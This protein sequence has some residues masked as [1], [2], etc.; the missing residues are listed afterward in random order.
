MF[1][2]VFIFPNEPTYG[3]YLSVAGIFLNISWVLHNVI[4]WL[5]NRPF[6]GKR[7][8]TIYI[9]TV[10]LSIPYWILEIT[11]NFLYFNPPY[12]PLFTH[13]RPWEALCR[14]V[15]SNIRSGTI[16]TF[17]VTRGGSSPYVH[18]SGISKVVTSFPYMRSSRYHHDSAFFSWQ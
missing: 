10:S 1:Q 9:V 15:H 16:L 6:L 2:S 7:V 5:K 4:A 13:T 3:W 11:A 8:S 17:L 14:F 12:N 18:F